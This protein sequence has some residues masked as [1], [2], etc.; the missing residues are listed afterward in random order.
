MTATETED[1]T[2]DLDLVDCHRLSPEQ[3]AEL[4]ATLL[5]R[6]HT[7]A[8]PEQR[9]L[10]QDQVVLANRGVA[11]AVAARYRNRGTSQ[12][13]LQQVAYE[14]LTKAVRRFDPALGE[15]LLTYAVPTI[16]GELQ[17]YFRDQGWSVRPPRR[18]MELQQNILHSVDELAQ[19]LGREPRDAEVIDRLC[20]EAR[21]YAEARAA[22]ACKRATSLDQ[23]VG[24]DGDSSLG[25]LMPG[26][27][28][29]A[30]AAE[31]RL[32]L[33]PAL[34]TLPERDREILYLRFFEDLTQQEIG[35]RLGVT[36]MQVSRLLT[37]I[38]TAL[39][40]RVPA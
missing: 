19:R 9:R 28:R 15:D 20:V 11:D 13:D 14:G 26:E 33:A 32:V 18:V 29:E 2:T 30:A 1:P 36:Q 35:E 24:V 3:R 22:F 38:L 25:A 4:T 39:R 16:R 40:R 12:E 8:C 5:A 7:V 27:D 37:R 21:D 6:A 34:R 10:L 23:P 31:A 17:R